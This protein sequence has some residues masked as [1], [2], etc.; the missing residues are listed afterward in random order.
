MSLLIRFQLW[1]SKYPTWPT[2]AAVVVLWISAILHNPW[3]YGCLFL[4]W[5]LYDIIS[6]R[7]VF[8]QQLTRKEH[9]TTFWGIVVTWIVFGV[10]S[11]LYGG[12]Q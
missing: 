2:W 7:S 4:A 8:L 12:I 9:P 3:I 6:G 5:A 11:I 10:G 1:S